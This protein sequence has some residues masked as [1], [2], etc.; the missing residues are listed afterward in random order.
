MMYQSMKPKLISFLQIRA[1]CAI[2]NAIR[3]E[4]NVRLV[5]LLVLIVNRTVQFE[6]SEITKS[7]S[8][9]VRN[10]WETYEQKRWIFHM[11]PLSSIARNRMAWYVSFFNS[12]CMLLLF[13]RH[14][15]HWKCL[16]TG[17][18]LC[19]RAFC[20]LISDDTMRATFI[21]FQRKWKEF[22]SNRKSLMKMIG[23]FA[24]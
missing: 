9:F 21:D 3:K 4:R 22:S 13:Q 24:Y 2:Y 19:V 17:V 1:F 16:Q 10:F 20:G 12:I 11:M 23:M 14:G 6:E 5:I 8:G 7:F 18:N 15:I